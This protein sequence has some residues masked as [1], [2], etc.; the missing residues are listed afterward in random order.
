MDLTVTND[1]YVEFDFLILELV[2]SL[3]G[4]P[5]EILI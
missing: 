3:G 2:I 5:M 1:A 4:G